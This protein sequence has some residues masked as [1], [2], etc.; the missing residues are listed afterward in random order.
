MKY[1]LPSKSENGPI[2][3]KQQNA[4]HQQNVTERRTQS[5]PKEHTTQR[6]SE[7]SKH[8][9]KS[10]SFGTI[11]RDIISADSG[12]G[13]DLPSAGSIEHFSELLCSSNDVLSQDKESPVSSIA[14]NNSNRHSS[15]E[16]SMRL[17][18]SRPTDE[19]DT[20]NDTDP[21][22]GSNNSVVDSH[23]ICFKET[24]E[25]L[26]RQMELN[27]LHSDVEALETNFDVLLKNLEISGLLV[28]ATG[29]GT[30]RQRS[31]VLRTLFKFV[32]VDSPEV[33][34][35]LCKIALMVRCLLPLVN[36]L[37]F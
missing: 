35:K 33:I 32:D 15:A 8:L 25:P 36:F 21:D 10:N 18:Q 11:A 30:A 9:R 16:S 37:P 34:L 20:T 26:L 29:S 3:S 14:S 28:K 7:V 6:Q 17:S 4:S 1:S 24:I 12:V 19:D 2:L 13:R 5:G 27:H 22:N 31:L 23:S